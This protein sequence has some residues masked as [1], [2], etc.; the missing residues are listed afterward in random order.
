VS[1]FPRL[2]VSNPC[3]SGAS[4]VGGASGKSVILLLSLRGGNLG[5]LA[6][7]GSMR[8]SLNDSLA[9]TLDKALS[10]LTYTSV[11]SGLAA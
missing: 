6:F 4:S 1:T 2:S 10:E 5:T 9:A 11:F 3:A 7:G 8:S